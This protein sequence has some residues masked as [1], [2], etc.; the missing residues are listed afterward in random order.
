[1]EKIV[2]K[3]SLLVLAIGTVLTG[4]ALAEVELTG[5]LGGKL[6][7]KKEPAKFEEILKGQRNPK[8]KDLDISL[9]GLDVG[10][11][12]KKDL[13]EGVGIVWGL[14]VK[15]ED[16]TFIPSG[17]YAGISHDKVG[18]FTFGAQ[19]G[20]SAAIATRSVGG[21][22][23]LKPKLSFK[24]SDYDSTKV[25][26]F[27]SIDFGGFKIAADGL[28]SDKNKASRYFDGFAFGVRYDRDGVKG[29]VVYQQKLKEANTLADVKDPKEY[30][31]R[32]FVAGAEYNVDNVAVAGWA[33]YDLFNKSFSVQADTKI[34]VGGGNA[35]FGFGYEKKDLSNL[36]VGLGWEQKIQ[37]VHNFYL[38]G[39]FDQYGF[40]NSKTVADLDAEVIAASTADDLAKARKDRDLKGKSGY[41]LGAAAGYTFTFGANDDIDAGFKLGYTH[42]SFVDARAD[43]LK[44]SL[45]TGYNPGENSKI[46]S[47]LTY[48]HRFVTEKVQNPEDLAKY[49]TVD[50]K[51]GYKYKLKTTTFSAEG[52]LTHQLSKQQSGS[53]FGYGA[54]LSFEHKF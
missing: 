32:K 37:G 50:F 34:G 35:K 49:S 20:L 54:K 52:N 43:V 22:K 12:G 23:E 15:V 40:A 1:M 5:K 28:A 41:S 3:K 53:R 48:T 25:I 46:T 39:L 6:E 14:G 33:G 4:N 13:G 45:V 26:K 7:L 38:E 19:D 24:T 44:A 9:S 18:K 31:S 27:E 10:I 16:N 8:D 11:E 17:T 2:M 47:E 30:D 51:L 42:N 36:K 29:G 21:F